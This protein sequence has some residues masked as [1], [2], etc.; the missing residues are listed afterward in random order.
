M[1]ARKLWWWNLKFYFII[2]NFYIQSVSKRVSKTKLLLY[3]KYLRYLHNFFIL[4]LEYSSSL[5]TKFLKCQYWPRIFIFSQLSI[6]RKTVKF[7]QLNFMQKICSLGWKNITKCHK[8]AQILNRC[9]VNLFLPIITEIDYK[10]HKVWHRA[11]VLCT[12]PVFFWFT[13]L[14]QLERDI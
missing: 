9:K 4:L 11:L 12:A 5:C 6:S 2:I 14:A 13:C 1:D 10:Y 3:A 7:Q 8:D